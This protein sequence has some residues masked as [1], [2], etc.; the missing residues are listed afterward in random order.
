MN[1]Y[2]GTWE[3]YAVFHG[4]ARRKEYW[5]FQLFNFIACVV[6]GAAQALAHF[7][8]VLS[9]LFSLASILPGIAVSVRRLH[10]TNRSG[11]WMFFSLIPIIGPITLVVFFATDGQPEEN[12]FGPSPKSGPIGLAA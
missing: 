2:F 5:Y 8:P 11:W 10:D 12:R 4:R 3:K 9:I 1:W 7:P 6:I